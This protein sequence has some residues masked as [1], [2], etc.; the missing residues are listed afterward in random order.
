VVTDRS[1]PDTSR[2]DAGHIKRLYDPHQHY[3]RTDRTHTVDM[4]PTRTRVM[5]KSFRYVGCDHLVTL[6]PICPVVA[7]IGIVE[8]GDVSAMCPW[9]CPISGAGTSVVWYSVFRRVEV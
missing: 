2:T 6:C 8:G 5:D 9:M 1:T 7:T 3:F 4:I